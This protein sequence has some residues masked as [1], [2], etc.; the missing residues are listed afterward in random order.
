MIARRGYRGIRGPQW[1]LRA[2]VIVEPA[3][4]QSIVG[5]FAS[6]RRNGKLPERPPANTLRGVDFYPATDLAYAL[7]LGGQLF[8]NKQGYLPNLASPE[9]FSEQI[10][11]RKYIAPVRMPSL[12]DKLAAYDY[13]KE[14]LGNDILPA[15]VWVGDSIAELSAAEPKRGR[16][17]LKANNG[18]TFVMFL[19]LPI[20]LVAKRGEI[21]SNATLWLESRFGYD[22]GEWQY[23]TYKPRLFLEEFLDFNRGN[24]PDDFKIFCFGGKAHLIEVDVDRFTDQ[25]RTAFYDPSWKHIPVA[26]RHAPIQRER[27]DN[28]DQMIRVA[29]TIANGMDFARIDL[30]S[31]GKRNIKFGEITFTPGN[32]VSRFSDPRFDK[33]LGTL[34]GE[35]PHEPFHSN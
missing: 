34:F 5:E 8:K 29:E 11:L 21:E 17:V 27:P 6:L 15:V 24:V 31:D 20:D 10:F 2:M 9:T 1:D 16:F 32:A 26:Y 4:A 35:G 28:L 7:A 22:W 14:R 18:C 33:W 23:C 19:D 25:L 3:V 30:Y 13:A 12:A